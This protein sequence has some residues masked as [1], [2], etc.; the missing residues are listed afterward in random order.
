[1]PLSALV[2]GIRCNAVNITDEAAWSLMRDMA[3]DGCVSIVTECCRSRAVPEVCGN[4][5]R[6][7]RAERCTHF[8]DAPVAIE[9]ITRMIRW[10]ARN[11][12]GVQPSVVVGN[13]ALDLLAAVNSKRVG[14]TVMN[15]PLTRDELPPLV[16]RRRAFDAQNIAWVVMVPRYPSSGSAAGLWNLV[17][18]G[19]LASVM[20]YDL[21][22][23]VV[24]GLEIEDVMPAVVGAPVRN[25]VARGFAIH[26][27]V[28]GRGDSHPDYVKHVVKY[29]ITVDDEVIASGEEWIPDGNEEVRQ[30]L[31]TRP[32]PV[33]EML[34][35]VAEMHGLWSALIL[36]RDGRKDG[37]TPDDLKGLSNRVTIHTSGNPYM[38]SELNT[39]MGRKY[40][41][42]YWSDNPS[43]FSGV[44]SMI[45][46]IRRNGFSV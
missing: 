22:T 21:N 25:G 26:L 36:F 18:E 24:T 11:G 5:Y 32:E 3:S 12:A 41:K 30:R 14:V 15:S 17:R 29:E 8:N 40:I 28:N 10:F 45:N 38:K 1:M 19:K 4:G 27:N 23:G 35:V 39:V 13:M 7:F 33:D 6:Y 16:A 43:I 2:S 9:M 44:K 31:A 37:I 42:T 46:E 20:E 34:K